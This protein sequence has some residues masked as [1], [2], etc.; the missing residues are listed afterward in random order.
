MISVKAPE[1]VGRWR[2]EGLVP[3]TPV[4]RVPL[5]FKWAAEALLPKALASSIV[6]SVRLLLQTKVITVLV[7]VGKMA[8]SQPILCTVSCS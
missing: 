6:A 2:W 3:R 1:T 5:L 4:T 8:S 7:E